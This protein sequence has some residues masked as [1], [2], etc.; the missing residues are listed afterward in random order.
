[1]AFTELTGDTLM[2]TTKRESCLHPEERIV[3]Y[4]GEYKIANLADVIFVL[5][6]S[7]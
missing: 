4:G 2:W 6:L 7:Q 3:L 1:M 5:R